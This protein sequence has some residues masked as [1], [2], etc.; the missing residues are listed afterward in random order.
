[1]GQQTHQD[2]C[3]ISDSFANKERSLRFTTMYRKI[4]F[5]FFGNLAYLTF[6]L[7]IVIMCIAMGQC[8]SAEPVTS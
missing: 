1:M 6:H 2:Q 5:F 4:L 3:N 8:Q 7:A